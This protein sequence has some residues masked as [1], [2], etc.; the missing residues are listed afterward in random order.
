MTAVLEQPQAID[1]E[2]APV[3]SVIIPVHND[4][5]NVVRCLASLDTSRYEHY[6]VIVM[7]DASTDGTADAAEQMGARVIRLDKNMGPAGARNLGAEQ[8]YGEHLLF[9][10]ADVCVNA[11]TLAGFAETLEQYPDADAVFGSY[12]NEPEHRGLLSQYRNLVHHFVHQSSNAEAA[13]FW[14]GCGAIRKST[15]LEHGGFDARYA[16][17]CIED[18]ELGIR[19]SKAGHRII[20]NRDIQ[21]T[22]LKHWTFWK[23]IKTD[24]FDRGVPWTELML[25]NGSMP[26]DLNLRF[27]QRISAL[28]AL[29][30]VV[31][32]VI[33]IIDWPVTALL[34]ILATIGVLGADRWRAKRY[35]NKP[36]RR[37]FELVVLAL[38]TVGSY[39]SGW[40]SVWICLPLFAIIALNYRFYGF[41]VR[42]RS[43]TFTMFVLPLHVLYYLYSVLAYGIGVAS[44]FFKRGKTALGFSRWDGHASHTRV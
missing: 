20:L 16:R 29:A 19:L 11:D 25:A 5:A 44:H 15:F 40:W 31:I 3:L 39:F 2:V 18:I 4:K 32:Q 8:A 9:I 10:D 36:S 41:F 28:F 38:F 30:Y 21:A 42:S 1:R 17:P 23:M 7:D 22:H 6:E 12:D 34:P 35:S 33:A 43:F 13:T 24:I 37:A 14:S 26:N 27:S